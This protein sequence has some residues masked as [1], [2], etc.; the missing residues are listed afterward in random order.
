MPVDGHKNYIMKTDCFFLLILLFCFSEQPT[1]QRD[2]CPPWFIPDNT[3]NTGCS[4]HWHYPQVMCGPDFPF[5]RFG[6]CMTYN[7]RTGATEY[8]ACPYIAHYNTT[9]ILGDVFF[10]Q[11][12]SNVS[13]LNEFMCGPL[14]REGPL[15][16]KCKDGYGI[17]LYSYTLECSKCWGHGYGWVLYYFLELFPITV[18][19][20]LV[21]TFHIRATSSPL[22]ALVFISQIVVYTIRLNVPFHMYIENEVTGFPYVAL[23]VLLVLCGIWSLDFFRSVVPPF[24]V[25]NNITSVHA[26]ALEYLVAF[27]PIFLILIT[28]VCIKLHDNNF[29]PIVWLWKP[30]HRYFVH[31]RRRW[32]STASIINAFTT[33]LLLSFSKILFVSFTL[34]HVST[35]LYRYVDLQYKCAL[36]YDSTVVCQTL[37]FALFSAIAYCVLVTFIISPTILLIL[38]PTRLFRKC[39]SCCGFRRWHALHIF[40]ESFQGQYKD[41]TNGT[42]D[43]RMVS[44]SFL[45]LRILILFLFLNHHRLFTHTSE[46]QG[47]LLACV[48]CLYAI[49]RPYKLNLMNNVDIVILFLLEILILVTST[50][51]SLLLAYIILATTLLLLIPHMILIFYICHKIAKKIGITQC[52][53]RKYKTLKRCVQ[54]TRPNS[55]AEANVETESDTGS[56]PDRLINPGEYEPVLPTTKEHTAAESAESKEP[57]NVEEPRLTPVFTYGSIN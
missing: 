23:K 43:F 29:R 50:S 25:S 39:V 46:L 34:L 19:Y 13:L 45:F 8:G 52:L 24:C 35:A 44:A 31:F 7:N 14:N 1:A 28:Y 10:I 49:T 17:A 22:S 56:L 3:S 33:F 15:C 4:C 9:T 6:F 53:K 30:F 36:Y 37:E 47:L 5:L 38:Y 57:D 20:F 40:V 18:M 51:G 27:Y 54:A 32:D 26:L 42:R 2:T 55:E 41:G 21:V 16:A 12:P 48:T 11:M